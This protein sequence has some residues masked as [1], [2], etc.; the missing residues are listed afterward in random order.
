MASTQGV[1]KEGFLTKQGGIVK[2]W[3]RRWFVLQEGYLYYYKNKG[4]QEYAGVVPLE[5]CRVNTA[6][7]KTGKSHAFEVC[8]PERVYYL[9]ADTHAGMEGWM[10]AIRAFCVGSVRETR[11][12]PPKTV[13]AVKGM[14]CDRCGQHVSKA[15]YKSVGVDSVEVDTE[16]EQVTVLGEVDAADI[17]QRLEEAGFVSSVVDARA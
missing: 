3:R 2:S 1:T 6:T 16:E 7:K 14:M 8:T 11:T 4:D 5:G 10:A 17:V 13:L 9:F 12:E 15:V